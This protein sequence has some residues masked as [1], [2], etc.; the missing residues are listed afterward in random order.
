LART[1]WEWQN[2]VWREDREAVVCPSSDQVEGYLLYELTWSRERRPVKVAEWVSTSDA[3]WRGLAG[4]LASLSD[5]ATEITYNAPR[6][7]PLLLALKEPYSAVGGIVEFVCYQA[8]RLVS[9]YTLRV[10]HLPTALHARRYPPDL[11]AD[12]LLRVDDPQ[13]PANNQTLHVHF[14][15]GGAN[16]APARSLFPDYTPPNVT[17]DIATFSQL[18]VGFISAENARALGRLRADDATCAVLTAAFAGAP[19]YLHRSDWF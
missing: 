7:D 12:V 1:E 17:T 14:A 19:L 13:L 9:G 18:Y 15:D 5:Q 3:A 4:F 10:V 6:E 2:Q 8:A 11:K 16:V